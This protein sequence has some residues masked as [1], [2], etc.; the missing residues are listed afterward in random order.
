[1]GE[2]KKRKDRRGGGGGGSEP[3]PHDEA[4]TC[5]QLPGLTGEPIGHLPGSGFASPRD[6]ALGG[7]EPA[8]PACPGR[9]PGKEFAWLSLELSAQVAGASEDPGLGENLGGRRRRK[10]RRVWRRSHPWPS[11]LP[12]PIPSLPLRGGK[13][14][15]RKKKKKKEKGGGVGELDIKICWGDGG[16]FLVSAASFLKQRRRRQQQQE[17]QQPQL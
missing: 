10:R 16:R 9:A 1:L 2:S 17:K 14:R 3:G 5:P 11:R 12:L 15:T 13:G 6:A 7:P 4:P 8:L